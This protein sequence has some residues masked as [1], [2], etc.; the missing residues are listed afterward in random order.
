MVDRAMVYTDVAAIKDRPFSGLSGGEKQRAIIA[1]A[2]AQ[3]PR[4]ILMDEATSHLDINHRFEVMQIVERLNQEKGVTVVMIS[5]DLALAADFSRRLVLLDHGRIVAD[6]APATVLTDDLLKSVYHCPIHVRQDPQSGALNIQPAR[7]PNTS[8]AGAGYRVHVVAGG[9]AGEELMRHLALAGYVFS[10]GVLNRGDSDMQ[11]AETLG[12]ELALEKP[13]SPIGPDALQRALAL[14]QPAHVVALTDVPFGPGNL[15]NLDL[16]DDA[17]RRGR[18]VLILAGIEQR[19]YTPDRSA[20]RRVGE[21]LRNG[22]VLC[23]TIADLI[24]RLPVAGNK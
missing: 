4:L 5:H 16:L 8:R 24:A 20:V 19:D 23:P 18:C 2:L 17:L 13:F 11:T 3:E 1:M 12:A 15:P 21:L 10:A 6:G 9:G 14:A 22:A 7:R